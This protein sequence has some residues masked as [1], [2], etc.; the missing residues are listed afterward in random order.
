MRHAA[1]KL[2]AAALLCALSIAALAQVHAA[3]TDAV[4]GEATLVIGRAHIVTVDGRQLPMER[5]AVIRVGDTIQT[6]AGGHVHLRFVD[7]GRVSVRPSSRLQVENYAYSAQQP[8]LSAIKF[9]LEEG[10]VRSIT[11]A[12]GEAARQRFR[13]NT[14][15]AAIGVKGTDFIV[16]ATV[17]ST[18]ATVFTGAITVAPLQGACVGTL[19]PCLTGLEKMLSEDMKGQM[20][21]LARFQAAPSLVS[22]SDLVGA[23]PS[24]ATAGASQ[25]RSHKASVGEAVTL[26]AVTEKPLLSET[27]TADV[28]HT[29]GTETGQPSTL[30]WARYPWAQQLAGDNFS[31][32]FE[33]AMLQGYERLGGN[34]AYALLRQVGDTTTTTV[35]NVPAAGLAS[36][37][38]TASAATVVL[39]EG[40]LLES[41]RIDHGTLNIDF[42]R[43][44]FDTQLLVTGPWL[45]ADTVHA[46]GRISNTGVM[47]ATAGNANLQGGISTHGRE[48]GFAF[49]KGVPAGVLQG[50]TL[51]GR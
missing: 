23:S 5:G 28:V 40:R 36:F 11:G 8:Q 50:I 10:V 39:D 15:L 16:R 4:V 48:A 32:R 33:T 31:Q 22:A 3:I 26:A 35:I 38:L 41:A 1:T 42:G 51:W 27:R 20:I 29:L 24:H 12:W 49:Q 46:A 43:S 45:G 44:T 18:A 2:R 19:G 7:G 37:Q 17:D 25:Q 13:L 21:E 6:E 9:K 34:G 30:S 47:Q 14:P